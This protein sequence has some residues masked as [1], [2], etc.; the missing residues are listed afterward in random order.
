MDKDPQCM[1]YGG[2]SP[3]GRLLEDHWDRRQVCDNRW[4]GSHLRAFSRAQDS[5]TGHPRYRLAA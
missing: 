2:T 4:L 1:K 3:S 5:I